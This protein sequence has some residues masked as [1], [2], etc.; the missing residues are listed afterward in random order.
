MRTAKVLGLRRVACVY[1]W[2]HEASGIKSIS[3]PAEA[4]TA[5][6][7]RLEW[8]RQATNA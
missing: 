8:H 3:Q 5:I 2:V 4:D 7:L 6:S 1:F